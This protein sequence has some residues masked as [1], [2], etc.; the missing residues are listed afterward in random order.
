MRAEM[1]VCGEWWGVKEWGDMCPGPGQRT[2][3][4]RCA[5]AG[6]GRIG[7]W[8]RLLSAGVLLCSILINILH[9]LISHSAFLFLIQFC[10]RRCAPLLKASL[11]KS[12]V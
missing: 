3:G 4:R 1:Q 2:G 8:A 7:N 11:R 10:N 5:R 9:D 6:E 12:D